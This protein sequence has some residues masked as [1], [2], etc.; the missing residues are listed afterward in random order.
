[1]QGVRLHQ[2]SI[3]FHAIQQLAQGLDLSADISDVSALGVAAR[4]LRS[5]WPYPGC[6]SRGTCGQCR[7]SRPEPIKRCTRSGFTDRTPQGLAVADQGV[8]AFCHARLSCHPLLQ[9]ALKSLY[10]ELSQ[11]QPKGGIQR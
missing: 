5:S 9:Q 10:V 11:Q 8:Q 3:E 2:H 4:L 6:W 1:M 7:R